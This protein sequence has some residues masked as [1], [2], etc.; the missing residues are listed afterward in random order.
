MAFWLR[1]CPPAT[2]TGFTDLFKNSAAASTAALR[3]ALLLT[4]PVT[5]NQAC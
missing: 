4:C 3:L 1:R 5:G 2:R